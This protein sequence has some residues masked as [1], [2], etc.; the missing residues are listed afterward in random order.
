MARYGYGLLL[1]DIQDDLGLTATLLGAIGTLAYA[2]YIGTTAL[3]SRCVV[4]VGQRATVVL[5][6]LLAV[7]DGPGLLAVGVGTAGASAGLVQPP[8]AD[9]VDRLPATTRAR[10]LAT[11][12]V[13]QN[14]LPRNGSR[15]QRTRE[16]SAWYRAHR[17][18][19]PKQPID[20]PVVAMLSFS[21]AAEC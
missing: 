12:G 5:G 8:F 3:V 18:I 21:S 19:S 13:L 15:R 4:R 11:G 9:A 6:G 17:N 14:V 7:A 20:S 10:T 16:Q 2:T 1:P